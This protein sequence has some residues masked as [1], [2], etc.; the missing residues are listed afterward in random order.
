LN[1][2]LLSRCRVFVLEL[3]SI[4]DIE[5]IIRRA[6]LDKKDGL[7]NLQVK[8]D[9][10]TIIFLATL[11][12]GDA[13]IALNIL[14]FAV[15]STKS[16]SFGK[17]VLDKKILKDSLKKSHFLYDRA[18]EEHYNIISALHKSIRG[19]NADAALY[20]LARMLEA[21]EDPLY[22][23]RRLIRMSVEDI[24]IANSHALEQAIACYHACHF[25]GM[26]ECDVILAQCVVYLAKSKKSVE[27]YQAYK[28]VKEDVKNSVDE[29]VPLHLRNAPTKL[30][31]E[32]G[33]GK[34]YK[35][36][37]DYEWKEDQEY[38]P[39]KLKGKKYLSH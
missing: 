34:E 29:P 6:L 17:I 33:Y 20:W 12:N 22:V 11:S 39:E 4:H 26:P 13:R 36:S 27:I 23:A 3:L 10:E 18:G 24:G 32:L 25:V 2:A 30:M 28:K 14:E 16:N 15:K 38:L 7:G 37:P 9:D 8:A 31:K 5:A 19:G 1:S 35:Y 21:G